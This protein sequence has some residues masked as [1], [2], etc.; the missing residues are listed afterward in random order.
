MFVNEILGS[1]R[2]G[3][4]C[5]FEYSAEKT[6]N[7]TSISPTSGP[8]G[9]FGIGTVITLL[10]SGFST[11][12]EENYVQ[13]GETTCVVL[14]STSD[15]I[16]CRAGKLFQGLSYRTK[17]DLL[18]SCCRKTPAPS[19]VQSNSFFLCE[20]KSLLALICKVNLT[21]CHSPCTRLPTF[22]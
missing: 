8:G 3:N 9:P 16:T 10:G 11:V 2:H 1:C 20:S 18:Q 5:T 15:N 13:I 17:I 19:P 21:N 6:P 7:L 12:N 22:C 4:N 14:S